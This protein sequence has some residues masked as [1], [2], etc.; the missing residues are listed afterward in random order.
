MAPP[1]LAIATGSQFGACL[2]LAIPGWVYWPTN[3]PDTQAW[4]G[5][6]VVG[7]ICTGVAYVLYFRLIAKTGGART[8]SVT[9]LIPLVANLVGVL[10][11]GESI[12]W[13]MSMYGLLILLGTALTTGL[14][15]IA[16]SK[17]SAGEAHV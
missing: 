16:K 14:L 9:Y 4:L 17:M 7:A 2:A 11:L 13:Q 10:V 12:T 5:L 6:L 1:P 8:L 3:M 15:P